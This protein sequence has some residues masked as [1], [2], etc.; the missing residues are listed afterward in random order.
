MNFL[1]PTGAGHAAIA[2]TQLAFHSQF[3]PGFLLVAGI[4]LVALAWWAYRQRDNGL[5]RWQRVLL[6][7]ARAVFLLLILLILARPVLVLTLEGSARQTLLLLCDN[8]ASMGIRDIGSTNRLERAQSLLTSPKINLLEQLERDYDLRPF[9]FG[10]TLAA[11]TGTNRT[12]WVTRL[13]PA[14][15]ATALGDAVRDALS[16]VRGRSLAGMVLLTDGGNNSGSPPLD[17][18]TLARQENVPLYIHGIATTQPKDIALTGL[19]P[20]TA[21]TIEPKLFDLIPLYPV[22]IFMLRPPQ[23]E[24]RPLI[25]S[26]SHHSNLCVRFN[27]CPSLTSGV[28]G[29]VRAVACHTPR[30]EG[31]CPLAAAS[32]DHQGLRA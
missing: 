1:L 2:K 8:S 27:P 3:A 14:G 25:P 16:S 26:L 29:E 6:A 32:L 20:H 4:V 19:M 12:D 23:L 7:S 17:A 24:A 28:S 31:A 30:A 13:A 11:A 5:A 21:I 22:F 9:V 18:A 15:N 10:R